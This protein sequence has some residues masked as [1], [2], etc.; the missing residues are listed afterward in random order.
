MS[1]SWGLRA[2]AVAIGVLAPL[3]GAELL[4]WFLPTYGGATKMPVNEEQ[5]IARYEPHREFTWSRDWNFSIVNTVQINNA[6]FVSDIDYHADAPGPLLAVVGDSYVEA[7]M[8]PYRHTCAGRLATILEPDARVYSFAMR[9]VPLGQYL[10]YARYARDAFRPQALVVVV[11]ENDLRSRSFGP[12]GI[13]FLDLGTDR[14]VLQ[15]T[16]FA[17]SLPYR[18]ARRSALVRYLSR[19]LWGAWWRLA[20]LLQTGRFETM[21][22]LGRYSPTGLADRSDTSKQVI[23][24]QRVIDAFLDLLPDYSGLGSE[25]IVFVV[26]GMRPPLYD[27]EVLDAL[28]MSNVAE[29]R[30]YFLAN[31]ARRGYETIDMQPRFRAHYRK[32]RRRF[33]WPQ[34][35]HW[36]ALGHEQCF[37]AVR[38]SKLLSEVFPAS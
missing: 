10:A 38:S 33:E 24:A 7:F 9:N 16:D 3:A 13:H 22:T 8:V 21:R 30:R 20:D 19:N 17:P 18:L 26:D 34:D 15:R 36:N 2:S 6:G 29:V 14:P 11:V 1:R 32:H 27:D 35:L 12:P 5:P 25:S 31:A 23:D 37:E 28:S 4:L